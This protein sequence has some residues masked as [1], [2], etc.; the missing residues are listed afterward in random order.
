MDFVLL[1]TFIK[2]D[3]FNAHNL[4]NFIELYIKLF[5]LVYLFLVLYLF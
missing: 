2:V 5:S 3:W 1:H 4:L